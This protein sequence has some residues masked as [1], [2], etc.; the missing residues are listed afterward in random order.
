[1]LTALVAVSIF[2]QGG[3]LAQDV[4]PA[5]LVGQMLAYYSEAKTMTGTIT[6]TI[7]A[8]NESASVMTTLQFERPG[9]LYLRQQKAQGNRQVWLT[10]ADGKLFAYNAPIGATNGDPNKRLI[11]NMIVDNLVLNIGDV[12][13]AASSSLGDRSTPL[14]IAIGRRDDLVYLRNQWATVENKGKADYDGG[15]VHVVMG[16]WRLHSGNEPTGQYRMY[17]T[18]AGELKQFAL[19]EKMANDSGQTLDILTTWDVKLIKNG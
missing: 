5:A 1:M 14:D 16:K 18:D 7:K 15:Q 6:E 19:S 11:E 17:I 4:S 9:K 13:S 8:G 12:Y 10:V 2:A 3:V